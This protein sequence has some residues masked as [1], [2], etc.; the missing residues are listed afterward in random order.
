[1]AQGMIK[2]NAASLFPL[3]AA[4]CAM[5]ALSACATPRGEYPDL[6]IRPE[7]RVSGSMEPVAAEPYIPPKTGQDVL[8]SISSLRQS[9]Q[10]AHAKFT[11][12]VPRAQRAANAARNSPQG[13]E[14]WAVAQIALSELESSRSDAMIALADLDRLYVDAAV[15]ATE[16][17]PLASARDDVM[18]LVAQE[19][20]V[21]NQIG[22]LTR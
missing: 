8:S 2:S 3:I 13:S 12:I 7:E 11:A 5:L 19:D 10:Q 4:G 20:S 6:A 21:I 9:A 22:S 17:G 14:N 18:A 16:L 15:N 1:M